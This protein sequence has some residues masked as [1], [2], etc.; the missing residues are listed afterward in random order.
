MQHNEEI[1][2]I[3]KNER[4]Q[5]FQNILHQ[6]TKG[7]MKLKY[8]INFGFVSINDIFIIFSY[9]SLLFSAIIDFALNC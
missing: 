5:H 1:T 7:S 3:F 4:W 8:T 2:I 6:T 9:V